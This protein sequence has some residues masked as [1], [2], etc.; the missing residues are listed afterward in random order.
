MEKIYYAILIVLIMLVLYL[1]KDKIFSSGPQI[2]LFKM[3]WCSF[4]TKLM[5]DWEKLKYEMQN[6]KIKFIT[7]EGTVEP[8]LMTTHNIDHFP[9]IRY[10]PNGLSDKSNYIE[11]KDN[12]S[13]PDLY[14][15]YV[16]FL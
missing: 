10:Y 5:P 11:H 2:V 14:K 8:S 4:C 13:Y 15:F 12:N 6:K 7:I 1:F 16:G 3:N 9:T